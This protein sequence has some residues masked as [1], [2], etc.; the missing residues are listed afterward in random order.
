MKKSTNIQ[1]KKIII[2]KVCGENIRLGEEKSI[3]KWANQTL[4][5]KQN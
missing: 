3:F 5:T 4:G 2:I 1:K